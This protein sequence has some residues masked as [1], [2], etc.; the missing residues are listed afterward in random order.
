M[1]LSTTT[2][3]EFK[4]RKQYDGLLSFTRKWD[5][6]IEFS[7]QIL[8]ATEHTY[9]IHLKCTD[10]NSTLKF[11]LFCLF[12]S[13]SFC[14]QLQVNIW[15]C[16]VVERERERDLMEKW[17]L[18]TNHISKRDQVSMLIVFFTSFY[19]ETWSVIEMTKIN[20]TV[21]A[22]TCSTTQVSFCWMRGQFILESSL[23]K[24]NNWT[25]SDMTWQ[26]VLSRIELQCN[27]ESVKIDVEKI[28][29]ILP[30]FWCC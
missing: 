21:I 11:N 15:L 6:K 27:S 9:T 10:L 25:D 28:V 22:L 3:N 26:H 18:P 17:N 20:L 5:T 1:L 19:H 24:T 16:F 7:L 8:C 2:D 30:E 23:W 12:K 13:L 14:L 4:V 29:P